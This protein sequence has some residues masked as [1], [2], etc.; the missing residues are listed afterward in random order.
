M[1]KGNS[2][3]AKTL[4]KARFTVKVTGPAMDWPANSDFWK[5]TLVT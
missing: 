5:V 1:H 4:G 3:S 2:F